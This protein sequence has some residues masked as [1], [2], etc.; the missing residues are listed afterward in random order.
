VGGLPRGGSA[1]YKQDSV[2][3]AVQPIPTPP[4]QKH[5]ADPMPV[6]RP[7]HHGIDNAFTV[8]TN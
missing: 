7:G 6:G 4:K 5:P 1:S 8:T 2:N 3:V